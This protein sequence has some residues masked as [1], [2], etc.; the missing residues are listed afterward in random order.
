MAFPETFVQLSVIISFLT[1]QAT[2]SQIFHDSQMISFFHICAVT[3]CNNGQSK[4]A[5][6]SC[7]CEFLIR[8]AENEKFPQVMPRMLLHFE[9][10]VIIHSPAFRK[11]SKLHRSCP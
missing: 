6:M 2:G 11:V 4:N 8:V 1:L 5:S 9:R 7:S 3:N 10:E